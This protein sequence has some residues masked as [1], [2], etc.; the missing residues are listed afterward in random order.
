[1]QLRYHESQGRAS[2]PG[3][4][5][6]NDASEYRLSRCNSNQKELTKHDNDSNARTKLQLYKVQHAIKNSQ[7]KHGV[8]E[9]I[10]QAIAPHPLG[11]LIYAKFSSVPRLGHPLAPASPAS[12]R[13]TAS[14]SRCSRALPTRGRRIAALV[15][16]AV[17]PVPRLLAHHVCIIC[18]GDE[19]DRLRG[20]RVEIRRGVYALLDLVR[21]QPVL[22]VYD[23]VM[24]RTHGSLQTRVRLEVEVEIEYRRDAFVNDRPRTRVPITIS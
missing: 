7:I 11:S 22:V 8:L 5:M 9:I 23:G 12:T 3:Y 21:A 13:S 10:V 4:R 6:M 14:T 15:Q 20:A 18:G 19:A 24:R 16:E 2:W 1:M 17:N